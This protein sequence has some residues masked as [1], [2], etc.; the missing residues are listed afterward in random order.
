MSAT[1]P[2]RP[3]ARRA[4]GSS[5]CSSRADAEIEQPHFAAVGDQDVVRLEVAV[6]DA[7]ARARKLPR[8]RILQ[9]QRELVAQIQAVRHGSIHPAAT[10]ST[11]SRREIWPA[12]FVDAGVVEAR[13]VRM[14]ERGEDVALSRAMR[15]SMPRSTQPEMRQLERHAALGSSRRRARPATPTKCR[16]CRARAAAGTARRWNPARA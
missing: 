3:C 5:A 13:D 12:A 11:Y 15:C 2:A 7:V 8:R 6:H 1:A 10:P 9:E 16:R 14:L 4:Q